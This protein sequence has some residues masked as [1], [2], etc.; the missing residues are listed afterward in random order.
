[1]GEKNKKEYHDT[2][3]REGKWGGGK[4]KKERGRGVGSGG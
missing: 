4:G 2:Y 1:M 3:V